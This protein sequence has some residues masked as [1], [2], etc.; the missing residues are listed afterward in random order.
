MDALVLFAATA[1]PTLWSEIIGWTWSICSVAVGLGFVIFVHELGHFL[2]AK[3][4][5]VKCE[6]FYI[7]FDIFNLRF[8]RFQWGETE[9]GIG[10]LPLG[11][12]V[13]MLGQDDDPRHAM[14]EAERIKVKQDGTATE[15]ST[16]GEAAP[17]PQKYE[18]DPR[19]YPAKSVPAR[20]AIISAGVIMNVIFGVLLAAWA[21][22][23]GVP[24]T[25]ADIGP[26]IPGT[27]AWTNNLEPGTKI[28]AFGENGAHYDHYRFEDVKRNIIFNGDDRDLTLVV[29]SPGGQERTVKLRPTLRDADKTEFPTIGFLPPHDGKLVVASDAPA[30]LVAASDPPLKNQDRVV[31][32]DGVDIGPKLPGPQIDAI[33]ARNPNR[34]MT[35]TVERKV[36][37]EKSGKLRTERINVQ[38]QPKKMRDVGLVMKIG[39][40]AAVRV[41]SPAEKAGFQSGDMITKVNG[42][43]V[44]DPLALGQ[45]LSPKA[46]EEA[47]YTFTVR[48]PA[49]KGE[50]T[51]HELTVNA[52]APRQHQQ[53]YDLGGPVGIESIGL[54]CAVSHHVA[55]VEEESPAAGKLQ[56]GDRLVSAQF[57]AGSDASRKE[58]IDLYGEEVYEE[59]KLDGDV[60]S[61]TRIHT[62]M[63]RVW[64]DTRLRV[65][66]QRGKE[67]VTADLQPV[68]STDFFDERRGLRFYPMRITHTADDVGEALSLGVREV[69]ERMTEVVATIA[70][71]I[72]RRVSPKHLS[73]PV[74]IITAAG[75]F[76][77]E[78]LPSLLIFLTIL[79][80]N[81]A[82]L[83][84]LPIP[85]LDGGHLL[86]LTWEG[87]TRKPV[88]PNV[89]GYLSLVG[90]VLLLLLMIYATK[91][92]IVRSFS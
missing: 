32:I 49:D 9:Y 88:N 67:V 3:A 65:K 2:V 18:L 28:V 10:A 27:P 45:R 12:Y 91:N 38:V 54:A 53:P 46:G 75:H 74:G 44:G 39:P 8:C 69:K 55:A 73:G 37:D 59:I 71:L 57:V 7:G 41:G 43:D 1:E 56:P 5:G 14:A 6:K 11:G 4:C 89:Q 79:S 58:E 47:V 23:L 62:L 34:P 25:P 87:I 61:W 86:F 50:S 16:S 29:A 77:S 31:S 92:D 30:H 60:E 36:E 52:E 63:Q 13:K 33:L 40:V 51:E 85:V 78:G 17:P 64:P 70:Q 83:N 66:V 20:M 84:I 22:W 24:E 48:R 35:L 15:G 21:Y 80:A 42:E 72:S 68:Q 82:I 26:T 81:L 19:S 76:A 90:L